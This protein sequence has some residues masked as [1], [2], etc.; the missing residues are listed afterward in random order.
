MADPVGKTILQLELVQGA[1][2]RERSYIEIHI[3]GQLSSQRV[4]LTDLAA[5]G[6]SAKEVVQITHPE[7]VTDADFIAFISGKD[8][9]SAFEVAQAAGFAGTQAEWLVSLKGT[10][11]T[12]GI[13]GKSAYEIAIEEGF[14][15]TRPQWLA[16]LIGRD[17]E[18]GTNGTNG[19]SNYELAQEAGFVGTLPE[20]L[21]SVKGEQGPKGNDG[22]IGV[23]GKSAYKLAQDAGFAGTEAEYLESLNGKSAYELAV[24]SGYEGTLEQ[25]Q[26]SLMANITVENLQQLL[27][28]ADWTVKRTLRAK[29]LDGALAANSTWANFLF[30]F[31]KRINAVDD[32]Y[33]FFDKEGKIAQKVMEAGF[34]NAEGIAYFKIADAPSYAKD[35][36]NPDNPRA[37][38]FLTN[39]G[40]F[41]IGDQQNNILFGDGSR[42]TVTVNGATS[43]YDISQGV[44]GDDGEKGET[45]ESA[46]AA[47]QAEGFEGTKA[48]WLLSLKG[49]NGQSAYELAVDAGFEG[50][51]TE[52]LLSINGKDGEDGT[53]GTNGAAG[54]SAYEVAVEDG[55]VGTA[56]QWLVTLEG[57][58]AYQSARDGGFVGSEAQWLVTLKGDKGDVG[59]IRVLGQLQGALESMDQLPDASEYANSD[60]FF[61]DG[62]VLMNVDGAWVDLG[63]FE[64]PAG[65]DGTGITILGSLP[66]AAAL[67]ETGDAI[68]D[69]YLIGKSMYVWQGELWQEQGQE[70]L[71]GP[72]GPIGNT[73]PEGKNAYETIKEANPEVDTIEKYVEFIRGEK[74]DTA[75]SFVADGTLATPAELPGTGVDNHGYLVGNDVDD[76]DFYVWVDGAWVN[77][78]N[79]VGPAG[80]VGNDG[81]VGPAGRAM[82]PKGSVPTVGDLPA[83]GNLVGDYYGVNG[84]F[85]AWDGDSWEDLGDFTGDQGDEGPA[86]PTAPAI[87]AKGSVATVGDL[88]ANGNVK[89][90][91]YEVAGRLYVYDGAAFVDMGL[92][93]G[94][95]GATGKSAYQLAVDAGFVGNE[96]A[97]RAS[98]KGDKG[99]TGDQ[100]DPGKPMVFKSKLDEEDEL[101]VAPEVAD[102]YLIGE[103]F[104]VW[105]GAAWVTFPALKGTNGVSL[106]YIGDFANQAALPA[107]VQSNVASAA[108]RVYIHNGTTWVDSGPVG[109]QG[110]QGVQGKSAYE[111]AVDAG[112]VGTN[113]Q[114]LASLKGN[115]GDT[116]KSLYQEAVDTGAFVG[117]LPEFI[118]SQKGATG[119]SA[120]EEAVVEGKLAE[121]ATFDDFL[122]L[123]EGPQGEVGATGQTGP[124]ISIIGELANQAALPANGV[125]GTGY[126]IPDPN[127]PGVYDCW[128]WLSQTNAWFNL[129]HVV[130]S[131]GPIGPQGN[132]GLQGLQGVKGDQ[133]SLWLV[134]DR[135]PQVQ[136]GRVNDYYFNSLTQEFFRKTNSTTWA[137]LGHIGGGNLNAPAADGKTKGMKDG[138][139]TDLP[140]L[141][142][143]PAADAKYKGVK[144]GAW[145]DIPLVN[146]IP[147]ADAKFKAVKDGA[148]A[149]L[150]LLNSITALE[151][152]A[153]Y[154][155]VNGA[156]VK[157]DTY[158]LKVLDATIT[159]N[160]STLD[161][162][163]ARQFRIV[164]NTTGAKTIN[165]TNIP[166]ADRATSVVVKIYGKTAV[167]NWTIPA[168]KGTLRWADGTPP[169]FANDTTTVVFNWDGQELVG[170]VPN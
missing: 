53:N 161:W 21:A 123:I 150:T 99:D 164:N 154:Q 46:Y 169:P 48:E 108:G 95:V 68:G 65:R 13:N 104:Y 78:G 47:A 43:V 85:Y 4:A 19:K 88:P 148:W 117:T 130:G 157:F 44:K 27:N 155:L 34:L 81:P 60:Y 82:T 135:D 41:G 1:I 111:V 138:V 40:R 97:W 6:L 141:N 109:A 83:V 36:A 30:L 162:N 93:R 29:G 25:W 143:I 113:A 37:Q 165:L 96:A 76:Y 128:I 153:A 114:W 17:G 103:T 72:I 70:G 168:G 159:A 61:V 71:R 64:G 49:S 145:A 134:F 86:G 56:T 24:E 89:G 54:K 139:W 120:F 5:R 74:G 144:D 124:A 170:F 73:G 105:N 125:V 3:V 107:G 158:T 146:S 58:S 94:P 115:T 9:K 140:L 112:F 57:K 87:T 50:D 7:V 66:N 14:I 63:K 167:F 91:G 126:A 8:G 156:W 92:W 163:L 119:L 59:P 42:I 142:S 160:A 100:G 16:S 121:D 151:A 77:L 84:H 18:D 52:W 22:T 55:Y 2:D 11:G 38:F 45:G 26:E 69:A 106:A 118:A 136:D 51:E 79:G 23:D 166:G 127:T 129:G 122:A 110:A 98:L 33:N 80:P 131:Q 149:D 90:D 10:N 12:N 102:A 75:V 35:P 32:D 39:T 20:Y 133:G 67:P 15:G 152:G 31:D 28:Q 147:V 137:S 132:R 101:P 62:H 116:G